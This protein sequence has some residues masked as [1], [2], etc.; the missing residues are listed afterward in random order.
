MRAPWVNCYSQMAVRTNRCSVPVRLIGKWAQV[1]LHASHLVVYDQNVEVGRHERLIVKGGRRSELD[2]YLEASVRK[3]GRLPRR[4]H[5]RATCPSGTF[6]PVHDAWWAQAPKI[7]GGRD[8]TRLDRGASLGRHIPY[9]RLV[10][11]LVSAL[12]ADS[13]TA[14]AV[15]LEARKAAQIEDDLPRPASL[16]LRVHEVRRGP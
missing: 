9:E 3:A 13:L 2:Y 4:H 1:V 16:T 6:L 10:A 14:D 5:A 15:A 12:R 8:G 11:G 7:H